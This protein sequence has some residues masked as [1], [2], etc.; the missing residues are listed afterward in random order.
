[1]TRPV[2]DLQDG[3]WRIG[4]T[5]G[6]VPNG[7]DCIIE[8]FKV[9]SGKTVRRGKVTLVPNNGGPTSYTMKG[10]DIE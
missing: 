10:N 1:M 9:R 7:H 6:M 3:K 8:G 4:D 2:V 5:I